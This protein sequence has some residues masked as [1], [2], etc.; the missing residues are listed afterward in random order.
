[1]GQC[2]SPDKVVDC[3]EYQASK[4]A[5]ELA[6]TKAKEQRK[7]QRA[8]NT[9]KNKQLKEEKEARQAA[10]QLAKDLQTANPTSR[11]VPSKKTKAVVPKAKKTAPTMPETNKARPK[12]NPAKKSTE[13]KA[14]PVVPVVV[15]VPEA[16]T[17]NRRGRLIRLPMRFK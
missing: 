11:K 1:M 10:A 13:M 12:A 6:E 5:I 3:R 8:A 2:Y 17:K 4:E 7:I 15:V 9:L 14:D 16:V